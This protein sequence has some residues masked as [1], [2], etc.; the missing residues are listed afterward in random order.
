MNL[1]LRIP[2]IDSKSIG[3]N[4][5]KSC[6]DFTQ[7]ANQMKKTKLAKNTKCIVSSFR[8][9]G[10]YNKKKRRVFA[11]IRYMKNRIG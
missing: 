4:Q 6:K 8:G 2:Y 11:I 9:W 10:R 3:N 5:V 7:N 1:V